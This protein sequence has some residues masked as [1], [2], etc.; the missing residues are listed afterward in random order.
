MRHN[1]KARSLPILFILISALL[2]T[3]CS[4]VSETTSAGSNP[5]TAANGGSS[6]VVESSG[7]A[8]AKENLTL[9]MSSDPGT[10]DPYAAMGA[11][12]KLVV[13]AV[14][15]LVEYN[16]QGEIIPLLAESWEY[17]EGNTGLTIHLRQGVTFSNG[18]PF[19]SADVLY[20]FS[21]AEQNPTYKGSMALLDWE[22][23]T[24][25][26][27]YTVHV[28]T[29]TS[30]GTIINYM[31]NL[32]VVNETEY[33][34]GDNAL[35]VI[36][37]G[38]FIVARYVA[39]D[40]VTYSA[41]EN[42]W[43][44]APAIKTLVIRFIAESSVRMVELE[45][46]TVDI[47]LDPAEKDIQRVKDGE[48]EGLSYYVAANATKLQFFGIN[49]ANISDINVRRAICYAIDSSA[50]YDGAYSSIGNIGSGILPGGW[51]YS[52]TSALPN[53]YDPEKARNL[54]AE[55]GYGDG[56]LSLMLVYDSSANNRSLAAEIVGNQ[57]NAVGIQVDL[58]GAETASATEILTKSNDYDLYLGNYG[59]L[60]EPGS[61]ITQRF[62]SKNNDVGG[63]G[64]FRIAGLS[65]FAGMDD[66]IAVA[67]AESDESKRAEIYQKI[68]DMVNDAAISVS[69]IDQY[70]Q[71]LMVDNLQ[72]FSFQPNPRVKEC[73]F[74]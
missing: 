33:S 18:A 71:C 51:W 9:V 1:S 27:E 42:Y 40:S 60:Y 62:S 8:S 28:P 13:Q 2:L 49:C 56:D 22:G 31:T 23:I 65:E 37:T 36:G 17:D 29:I 43:G 35:D 4:D 6:S 63:S 32:F 38:A 21:V 67:A 46:R 41:N 16:E 69:F 3:A 54:L 34:K 58:R 11:N 48:S 20:S 44:G 15:S 74:D 53:E 5:S 59:N 57:L 25:V 72:G 14:E 50:V 68:Q 30:C 64:Y 45:N 52:S 26:D 10:I 47:I 19:T 39:G 73:Y 24:A 61:C 55:A 70:D 7:G 12:L 66:L